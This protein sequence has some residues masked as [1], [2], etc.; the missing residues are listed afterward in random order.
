M[1]GQSADR[2]NVMA[3]SGHSALLVAGMPDDI[4]PVP[5]A[6]PVRHFGASDRS[7]L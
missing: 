7:Y 3:V 6:R 4:K 1:I 2:R 5:G